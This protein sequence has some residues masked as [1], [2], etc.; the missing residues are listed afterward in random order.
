MNEFKIIDN[1]FKNVS[2]ERDDVI[3]GSGDDAACLQVPEGQHLIVTTDTL[4]SGVHFLPQWPAEDIAFKSVMVNISDIAAMAAIPCW[5]SI[6][7]TMPE[8]DEDWL[9]GFSK[10]LEKALTPYNISLIGGDLTCGP[11]AITITLHGL[12]PA[13]EAVKRSGAQAGDLIYV[14]GEL[15][16][17]ALAVKLLNE[18]GL[19]KDFETLLMNALLYPT[20]G[21]AYA[22]CLR[23][24]ATAAIDIS[25]GLSADLQHICKASGLGACIEA[26]CVPIHPAVKDYCGKEGAL[27]LALTGGDDY[28][29]CFTIP[30]AKKQPFEDSCAEKKLPFYCIGMMEKHSGL[31]LK[32]ADNKIHAF[33]A[34]GYSH[35]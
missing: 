11:L 20:P 17:P 16:T 13:G 24:Y 18:K 35:F 9:K 12:V 26:A 8:S 33:K 30:A 22:E 2:V 7:L 23:A 21:V 19:D 25:D 27:E 6:A 3:I 15:G 14:T 29:L 1:Y 5:A 4:V 31:R 34:K 32:T 28:Q 10:G